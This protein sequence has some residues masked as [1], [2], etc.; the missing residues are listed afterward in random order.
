MPKIYHFNE[1]PFFDWRS[2]KDGCK[3]SIYYNGVQSFC[4]LLPYDNGWKFTIY[5][6][7]GK[8]LI[9][10]RFRNCTLQEAQGKAEFYAM[11][12]DECN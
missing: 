6:M 5:D 12:E 11:S 1:S 10:Y 9:K 7:Q 4:V 8:A 3:A 2:Y